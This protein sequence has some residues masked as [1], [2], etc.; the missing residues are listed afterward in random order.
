LRSVLKR[1]A[2]KIENLAAELH[3]DAAA[4]G[5]GRL[6]I[7]RGSAA[8]RWEAARIVRRKFRKGLRPRSR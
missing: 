8:R 7:S 4:E 6:P 2:K 1:E 3:A 5:V